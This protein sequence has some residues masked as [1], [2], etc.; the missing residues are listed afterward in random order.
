MRITSMRSPNGLIFMGQLPLF[1]RSQEVPDGGAEARVLRARRGTNLVD[2]DL[3]WFGL[4]EFLD[5]HFEYAVG[6]SV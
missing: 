2:V 4:G 6:I 3:D 5:R 1:S